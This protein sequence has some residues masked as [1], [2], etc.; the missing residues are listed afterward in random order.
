MRLSS[1]QSGW[2]SCWKISRILVTEKGFSFVYF[3]IFICLTLFLHRSQTY[4]LEVVE[5]DKPYSHILTEH[6]AVTFFL[7]PK[8]KRRA[9]TKDEAL[10]REPKRCFV[11]ELQMDLFHCFNIYDTDLRVNEYGATDLMAQPIVIENL[12]VL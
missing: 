8:I 10:V 7:P 2:W 9:F 4:L 5:V 11:F 1:D 3:M 12:R 6:G